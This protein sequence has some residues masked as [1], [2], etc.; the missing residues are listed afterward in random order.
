MNFAV[1]EDSPRTDIWMRVIFFLPALIILA[2]IV[3]MPD[4]E[5]W[6]P[7]MLIIVAVIAVGLPFLLLPTRLS[8]L[9]SAIR[10]GFRLPFAFLIPFNTVTTLRPS[11]WS[12]VGINLPTNLSPKNAVEI[13]RKHRL[14]VTVT[15]SD[16]EAFIAGF[17]KAFKE[18][19]TY[20]G[21]GQ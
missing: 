16:R 12:T 1:Y 4:E 5:P 2:T 9:N 17:D 11:R 19:K 10:I 20:E 13:V 6:V 14:S 3:I 15:P 18:W 7:A 21:R 8:I